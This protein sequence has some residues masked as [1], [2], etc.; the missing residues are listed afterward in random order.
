MMTK[1]NYGY[2]CINMTLS[3][4]APKLRVTTNRTMIKKTFDEKGIKYASSLSLQNCT[5]LVKIINWNEKNGI[6]FYRLSSDI[7]PWSSHYNLQDLPDISAISANLKMA[8]NLAKKFGQRLS[9]H[10]GPFNKLSSPNENVVANTIK[11]LET[12]GQIFDIMGMSKTHY[13]KINIHV[14]AAY[15]D[16]K[17]ALETFLKNFD[18]LSDSVKTRLTV[19]NDDK[20]GLYS[21]KELYD[22]VFKQSNIPIVFDYHHHRFCGGGLSEL[23]ALDMALSTWNCVRPATHYS[24]SRCDHFNDGSKPQAHSDYISQVINTYN[25]EFDCMIEAKQKELALHKYTSAILPRQ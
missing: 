21:T 12:H 6:K 10:P 18:R 1:N 24:E 20:E 15:D 22:G 16:K 4:V 5:D 2:A 23:E 19:E 17:V 25:K 7:F 9:F 13:N 8:G 14:G 11:D 3:D